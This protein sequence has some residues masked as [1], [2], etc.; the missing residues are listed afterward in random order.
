ME[1]P[2]Y[3]HHRTNDF[4]KDNNNDVISAGN[5]ELFISGEDINYDTTN[6]RRRK[7]KIITCAKET[8]ENGK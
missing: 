1:I 3:Q 6:L 4:I 7:G 8:I 5:E 2:P